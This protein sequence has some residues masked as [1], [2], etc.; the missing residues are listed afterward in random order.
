[1]ATK[2]CSGFFSP[3]SDRTQSTALTTLSCSHLN[4]QTKISNGTKPSLPHKRKK[5]PSLE[6]EV[7]Y[8]LLGRGEQ[9]GGVEGVGVGLAEAPE[10]GEDALG[11]EE[12]RG[13]GGGEEGLEGV[14]GGEEAVAEEVVDEGAV[15]EHPVGLAE[16]EAGGVEPDHLAVLGPPLHPHPSRVSL[17]GGGGG[18]GEGRR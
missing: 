3:I 16:A 18:G 17:A 14:V 9:G 5:K 4:P 15:D 13:P 1:M 6:V 7:C 8:Y 11:G 10:L 2:K 12:G